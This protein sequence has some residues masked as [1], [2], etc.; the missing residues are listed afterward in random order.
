[1]SKKEYKEYI[2]T[3][4]LRTE[5]TKTAKK[6]SQRNQSI[7]DNITDITS[8]TGIGYGYQRNKYWLNEYGINDV[9]Y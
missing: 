4:Y 2:D 6:S 9:S 1:M 5:F 3:V 7:D 8:V